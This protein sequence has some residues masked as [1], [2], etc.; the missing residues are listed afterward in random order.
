VDD[1]GED[2]DGEAGGGDEEAVSTA[3]PAAETRRQSRRRVGRAGVSM[4]ARQSLQL[5]AAS[6]RRSFS[7]NDKAARAAPC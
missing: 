7:A 6:K 4:T 2:D 3:R 1:D 5:R